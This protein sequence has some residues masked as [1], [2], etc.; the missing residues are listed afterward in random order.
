[1]FQNVPAFASFSTNDISATKKFYSDILGLTVTEDKSMGILE[2]HLRPD[3]PVLIYPKPDHVPAVFTV[4]NFTVQNV[5]T[6]VAEL[7]RRGV[8]FEQYDQPEL[9]TDAR[10]ISSDP[11]TPKIAWF[12]DPTGNIISILQLS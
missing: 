9:K 4:L 2:L 5:D 1:M 10:G 6:T 7:T 11:G 8:V 3:F 12:K